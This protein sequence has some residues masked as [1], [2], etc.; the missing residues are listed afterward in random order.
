MFMF[1]LPDHNVHVP[2]GYTTLYRTGLVANGLRNCSSCYYSNHV[3]LRIYKLDSENGFNPDLGPHTL[4]LRIL[5]MLRS[6]RRGQTGMQGVQCTWGG[7]LE[8]QT[9]L[10]SWPA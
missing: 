5:P 10:L 4:E 8:Y 9:K 7:G 2:V 1:L 3:V 6:H